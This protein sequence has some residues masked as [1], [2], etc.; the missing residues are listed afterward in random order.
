MLL[1]AAGEDESC[2]SSSLRK[3]GAKK[4]PANDDVMRLDGALFLSHGRDERHRS[5]SLIVAVANI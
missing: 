5:K 4:T 3:S 2:R 1:A